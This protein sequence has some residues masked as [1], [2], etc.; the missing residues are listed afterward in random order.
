M[1][2]TV[3]KGIVIGGQT[4]IEQD[5]LPQAF[6]VTLPK[7]PR[8]GPTVS[9]STVWYERIMS[10]YRI[11]PPFKDIAPIGIQ[12]TNKGHLRVMFPA[13]AE[14]SRI[15]KSFPLICQASKLPGNAKA[16]DI[17][18]DVAYT[19]M[20][21]SKAPS[22]SAM[23]L[24]NGEDHWYSEDEYYDALVNG[25]T[26]LFGRRRANCVGIPITMGLKVLGK[27]P[28]LE[29]YPVT[30]SFMIHDEDGSYAQLL[31]QT[32]VHILGAH[33]PVCIFKA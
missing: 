7:D 6:I 31:Q 15:T 26:H 33:C 1:P 14:E 19:R 23:R 22:F 29:N 28:H 8:F 4:V 21:V 25:N 30:F 20:V 3:G 12:Y 10:S 11:S 18:P 9:P 27:Q 24:E 5:K 2:K 16:N 17:M 13:K 32:G